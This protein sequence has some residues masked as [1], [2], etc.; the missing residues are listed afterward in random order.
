MPWFHCSFRNVSRPILRQNIFETTIETLYETKSFQSVSCVSLENNV[1]TAITL[2]VIDCTL[3]FHLEI[4]EIPRPLQR[5]FLD[6]IFGDQKWDFFETQTSGN[7]TE[8]FLRPKF[9]KPIPRLFLR[10]KFS[11]PI[12]RLFV[13]TRIFWDWYWD[14]FSRPSLSRSILIFSKK[15]NKSRY[16]EVLRRDVTCHTLG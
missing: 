3:T 15:W 16:R 13:E 9:L 8:T 7:D 6:Q 11:R 12:L 4:C 10:S 1:S 2:R 14:F 5:L